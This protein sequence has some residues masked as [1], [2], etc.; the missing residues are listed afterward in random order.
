MLNLSAI[1]GQYEKYKYYNLKCILYTLYR[2]KMVKKGIIT[3][4]SFCEIFKE[5]LLNLLKI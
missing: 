1:L 3:L 4:F 2:M 5:A